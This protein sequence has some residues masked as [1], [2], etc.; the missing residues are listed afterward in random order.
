MFRK[1][2][3]G[4]IS[5]SKASKIKE[6]K[7]MW[8]LFDGREERSGGKVMEVGLSVYYLAPQEV[9][10]GSQSVAVLCAFNF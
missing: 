3:N 2:K 1:T 4:I 6:L 10:S 9:C 7:A 8:W 5:Q